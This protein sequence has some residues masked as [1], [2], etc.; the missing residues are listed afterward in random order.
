MPKIKT[1]RS[2]AKRF[3]VTATGKVKKAGAFKNHI[4]TKKSPKRLRRL[5]QGGMIH[6]TNLAEVKRLLPYS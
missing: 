3:R 5:A 1:K 6:E 4:L 2:A